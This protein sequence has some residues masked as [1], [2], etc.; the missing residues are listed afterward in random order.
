ME[1]PR[2]DASRVVT[3]HGGTVATAGEPSVV[4]RVR[5]VARGGR[6]TPFA[7]TGELLERRLN[8]ARSIPPARTDRHHAPPRAA[9]MRV[10]L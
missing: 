6:S 10:H 9:G 7:P 2:I 1:C 4:R 3:R 5:P 8:S